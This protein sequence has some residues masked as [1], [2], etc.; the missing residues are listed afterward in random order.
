ME[1]PS[2][3]KPDSLGYHP[4]SQEDVPSSPPYSP[5][6]PQYYSSNSL[7]SSTTNSISFEI[8]NDL[9]ETE[10]V[11]KAT[12]IV[13][14]EAAEEIVERATPTPKLVQSLHSKNRRI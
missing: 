12:R 2:F 10:E 1:S 14:P 9:W 7:Y 11:V 13:A 8:D 3:F 6:S 5:T 4:T